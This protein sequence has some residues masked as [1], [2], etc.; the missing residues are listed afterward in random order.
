MNRKFKRAK[1]FSSR[2]FSIQQKTETLIAQLN[3]LKEFREEFV[4]VRGREAFGRAVVDLIDWFPNVDAP[5]FTSNESNSD[6]GGGG[7]GASNSDD[8][9]NSSSNNEHASNNDSS[10]EE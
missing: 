4:N 3:M 9:E 5:I 8:L 1:V 7:G 6:G 2:Y 10:D